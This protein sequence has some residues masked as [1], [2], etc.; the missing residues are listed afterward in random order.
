MAQVILEN[1]GVSNY[2]RKALYLIQEAIDF[3]HRHGY[4]GKNNV[5][6]FSLLSFWCFVF[7]FHNIFQLL[8][9]LLDSNIKWNLEVAI[10]L[11]KKDILKLSW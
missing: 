5:P 10:E 4:G 6:K 9:N 8:Y 1:N 11:G 7:S 2:F 3:F